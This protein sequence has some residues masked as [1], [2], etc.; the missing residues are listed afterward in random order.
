MNT[1]YRLCAIDEPAVC[2]RPASAVPVVARAKHQLHRIQ[3]TRV[4]VL[5]ARLEP[6]GQMGRIQ[7]AV[8]A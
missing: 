1:A 8:E 6:V 3:P 2:A 4:A 7:L 5:T